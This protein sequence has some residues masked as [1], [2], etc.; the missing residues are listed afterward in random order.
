MFVAKL[1]HSR[2]HCFVCGT[3]IEKGRDLH[4][5]WHLTCFLRFCRAAEAA[6]VESGG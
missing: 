2:L 4:M 1:K 6:S 3:E 5:L